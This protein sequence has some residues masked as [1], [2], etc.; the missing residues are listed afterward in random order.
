[1]PNLPFFGRLPCG[2]AGWLALLL[3]KADDVETNPGPTATHK[4]VWICDICHQQIHG[5]KQISIMCNRIEHWVHLRSR[6]YPPITIY[7]YLDLPYTEIIQTHNSHRHNTTPPLQTLPKPPS[8]LPT[9]HSPPTPTTPPQ[10]KHTSNTHLFPTGL[11]KPKTN[12]LIY[13][14]PLRPQPNT[15]TSHILH[16]L[17]SS[18]A[19]HSSTARQ[20]R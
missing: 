1:M 4:Q 2:P 8:L 3:I 18:H 9:P 11:V 7:R 14:P 10:P 15:Y 5:R 12:P 17:S 6:R 13:S 16:Q 19:P 20:L